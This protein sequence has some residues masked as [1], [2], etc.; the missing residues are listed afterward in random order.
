MG[1][2]EG[3][4]P[5]QVIQDIVSYLI[6]HKRHEWRHNEGD[7]LA[8]LSVQVGGQLVTQGLACTR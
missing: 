7:T 2:N 4:T 8:V 3:D 1:H 6:L 5:V